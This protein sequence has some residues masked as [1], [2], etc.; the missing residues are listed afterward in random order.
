MALIL[1]GGWRRGE[2]HIC[3]IY[4]SALPAVQ[5]QGRHWLVTVSLVQQAW[6]DVQMVLQE[7]GHC[8]SLNS[9]TASQSSSS[10][11]DGPLRL[12]ELTHLCLP[13]QCDCSL[14]FYSH[15]LLF[16]HCHHWGTLFLPF[17]S[18]TRSLSWATNPYWTQQA[19]SWPF[20]KHPLCA[21]HWTR[22]YFFRYNLQTVKSTGLTWGSLAHL[23][24][25]VYLH[26]N[27]Q[28]YTLSSKNFKSTQSVILIFIVEETG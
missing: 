19:Q 17:A 12:C 6:P 2:R 7:P 13:A 27:T 21:S 25:Y 24:K 14:R 5:G 22:G 3:E 9:R 8:W 18:A 1:S 16:S 10:L 15:P 11:P 26:T 4:N 28:L 23:D 20:I